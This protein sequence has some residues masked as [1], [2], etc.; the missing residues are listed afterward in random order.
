MYTITFQIATRKTCEMKNL[1]YCMI[2]LIRKKSGN[3]KELIKVLNILFMNVL[4]LSRV[5]LDQSGIITETMKL[6]QPDCQ[7]VI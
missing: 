4:M 3:F 1:Y 2:I 5:N 6:C 7:L